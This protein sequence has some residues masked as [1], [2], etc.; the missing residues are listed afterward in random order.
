MT[1]LDRKW[2]ILSPLNQRVQRWDFVTI[3]AIIYTAT[4]MPFQVA[5][6]ASGPAASGGGGGGGGASASRLL[7]LL[8]DGVFFVDLVLQFYIGYFDRKLNAWVFNERYIAHRYL[9]GWFVPDVVSIFPI[10]ELAEQFGGGAVSGFP[11]HLFQV[12]SIR[13]RSIDREIGLRRRVLEKQSSSSID[14]EI[15]L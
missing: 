5:V 6:V 4:V 8:V 7:Q 13:D 15:V 10:E 9:T 12:R 11:F 3:F 14:R 1:L 2:Y